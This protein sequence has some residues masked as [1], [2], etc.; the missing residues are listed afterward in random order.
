MKKKVL[1][2]IN[3]PF[4]NAGV[5]HVIMS[6]VKELNVDYVFDLLIYCSS[7]EIGDREYEFLSFGGKIFK[8]KTV[9][10]DDHKFTFFTRYF[11]LSSE[12]KK[13][14]KENHY[15]IV[16]CHNGVE[17]GTVLHAAKK[18]KI[19][20]RV[21]HAHGLY[22]RKGRNYLLRLFNWLNKRMI[23]MCSTNRLACSYEAGM[24][25]YMG[26]EFMNVLNPVD[27]SYYAQIYHQDHDAINMIQI[28]Y[29]CQN[30]NQMMSLKVLKEL[31]DSGVDTRM[32]FIGF[33]ADENY[34][35]QLLNY[36][37]ENNLNEKV[38]ILDKDTDKRKYFSTSDFLLLPSHSEGLSITTL[39]AQA[40]GIK[41]L[42]SDSVPHD[43]DCGLVTFLNNNDVSAWV[44]SICLNKDIAMK[45]DNEKMNNVDIKGYCQI[46][47]DVYQ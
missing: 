37:D 32:V 4:A 15:D 24:S 26:A 40:A 17:A 38:S 34:Y 12:V 46:I 18:M 30:K 23:I 3:T 20:N 1:L 9:N 7:D 13:L 43:C 5:P 11:R 45:A 6:I 28:G 2:V 25:M 36:I 44:S 27:V 21:S 29:F 19:P 41:C 39:E 8:L 42:V 22:N 14:I 47:R 35:R 16:H 31:I 10:Y 33:V